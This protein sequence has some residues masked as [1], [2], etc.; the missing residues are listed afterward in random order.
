MHRK[1]AIASWT[2]VWSVLCGLCGL[3]GCGGPV[4]DPQAQQ[5][6]PAA[7]S[8]AALPTDAE[9]KA[10]LDSALE[11]AR[12]RELDPKVHNAWQVVHGILAFNRDLTFR[13]DGKS[14]PA[15]DYLLA[16]GELEG[17]VFAPGEKGLNDQLDPGSKVGAGHEDQWL[18]YL[19]QCKLPPETKFVY[20]GETFQVSDLIEQAKWDVRSGMEATWTLMG[21]STYLPLDAEWQ[22]RDGSTWNL[23]RLAK[24]EANYELASSACGGSH[25]LYG[26]TCALQKHR[27]AGKPI[28]PGSGWEAAE[29]RVQGAIEKARAYQQPDGGFSINFF[30]RSATS[31][32][33]G[34]RINTTGHILEFLAFAM[35]DEEL[36]QPWVV[37]SADYLCRQFELTKDVDLE[38][39]GLYH[40]AHGLLLYRERLFGPSESTAPPA[41]PVATSAAK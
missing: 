3:A 29:L 17:W 37:R 21:L 35:T 20:R 40:A 36:R 7:T 38:C 26:L 34:L 11:I 28:E 1:P 9:L 2:W 5:A 25:R 14:V 41:P 27:A 32:D 30:E 22:A 12:S 33:L 31:P 16:G 13:V 10:R 6:P 23:E 39:G 15:L 4:V 18:G 8:A 24:M 19:S